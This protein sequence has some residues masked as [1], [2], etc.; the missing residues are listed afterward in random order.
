MGKVKEQIPE[1]AYVSESSKKADYAELFQKIL[2]S[3][4]SNND[5]VGQ[6]TTV[7]EYITSAAELT[8]QAIKH[9]S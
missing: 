2:I 1:Y 3:L 4:L 6:D 8:K 7:E 9:L 5:M